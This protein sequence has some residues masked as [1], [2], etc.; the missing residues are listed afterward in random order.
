MSRVLPAVIV[1]LAAVAVLGVAGTEAWRSATAHGWLED[2]YHRLVR[3]AFWYRFD[4]TAPVALGVLLALLLAWLAIRRQAPSRAALAIPL[5]VVTV[6]LVG[7]AAAFLDGAAPPRRPNVLLI[8]IDTLRPD[9]LGTHGYRRPTSPAV[10][11][12]LAAEGVVFENAW[13][14]SPKTTPSHMTMLTSLYPAVH[15]IGLW[16]GRGAAPAL[17]PRV[18]TLAEVL[19]DAGYATAAFTAGAHMH[20]DRGFVQGF[21]VYKHGE[22]LERTL[23]WLQERP[24]RPFFVFFHTYE[25]HDP[26]VPPPEVARA[27]ADDPVP[28]IAAAVEEIRTAGRHGWN[29]GHKRFWAAVD[30]RDPR[31]V[32]YVSDLYDAGIRRMD[33]RSLTRLL[34]VLDQLGLAGET[35]VVFT[36]DHGEA[37]HEHGRFLHDDLYPETLRV[38]LVL[39]LPGRLPAGRRVGEAVGLVDLVPTILDLVGVPIPP[40]AQ[41]TS[42]AALARGDAGAPAPPA[43]LADY[44]TAGHRFESARQ[45]DLTVIRENDQVLVYDRTA[46]PGE[47][48]PLGPDGGARGAALAAALDRWHVANAGLAARLGPRSGDVSAPSA[49]TVEQL[50]ALGYV[51]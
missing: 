17:N 14:Q 31:H 23:A 20:R 51:E 8:S 43:V 1:V 26:Y 30:G 28:S 34:D 37:F 19:K 33:D 13:S 40:Q 38:P 3:Q 24:R 7:R 39:R 4:R 27:F 10:D 12:R 2:G 18:H 15:G 50:R 47:R 22:Q 46:D 36:S 25:V 11:A 21:D 5:V 49:A 9:R 48:T 44:T 35:L 45:A 16:L 29:Q 32:R 6:L 41:G 42:L